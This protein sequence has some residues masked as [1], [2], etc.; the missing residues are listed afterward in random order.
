[1]AL[2]FYTSWRRPSNAR[3]RSAAFSYDRR[4][5]EILK[6][7]D[8]VAVPGV[9]LPGEAE[10]ARVSARLFSA[11]PVASEHLSIT[12]VYGHALH[13]GRQYRI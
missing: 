7:H 13:D 5:G 8:A 6:L 10:L 1:M 3:W 4:T 11:S 12:S 9:R 2:V